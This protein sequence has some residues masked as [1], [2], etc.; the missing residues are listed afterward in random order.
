LLAREHEVVNAMREH[1]ALRGQIDS[2]GVTVYEHAG[3]ARLM[4]SVGAL[5]LVFAALSAKF[6]RELL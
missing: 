4:M 6:L 3:P 5:L 2:L 1:F